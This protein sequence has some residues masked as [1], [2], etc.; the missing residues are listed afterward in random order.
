MLAGFNEIGQFALEERMSHHRGMLAVRLPIT[1]PRLPLSGAG[2]VLT[3]S[4][5]IPLPTVQS[6]LSLHSGEPENAY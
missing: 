6:F 4:P 3:L 5:I 2:V 1:R